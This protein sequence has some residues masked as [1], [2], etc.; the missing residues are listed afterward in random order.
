MFRS[1]FRY[2]YELFVK[3]DAEKPTNFNIK[4]M[5][6]INRIAIVMFLIGLIM[7]AVKLLS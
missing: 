1:F 5:H 4:A 7:L 2:F 3:G 6:H